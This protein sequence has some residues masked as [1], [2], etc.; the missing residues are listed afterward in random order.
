MPFVSLSSVWLLQVGRILDISSWSL[1]FSRTV[2][3]S[4]PSLVLQCLP[5]FPLP[6]FLNHLLQNFYAQLT[7]LFLAMPA[8]NPPSAAFFLLPPGVTLPEQTAEAYMLAY[9]DGYTLNFLFAAAFPLGQSFA[10]IS[11]LF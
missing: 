3:I 8:I 7:L 11:N 4:R 2:D 6:I 9:A 1:C 5:I 10:I